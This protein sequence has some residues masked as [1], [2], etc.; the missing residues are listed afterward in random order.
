VSHVLKAAEGA[1]PGPVASDLKGMRIPI[2]TAVAVLS[3]SG[4]ALAAGGPTAGQIQPVPEEELNRPVSVEVSILDA[5]GATVTTLACDWA[6]GGPA[7]DD[8]ACLKFQ[9]D[10]QVAFG[11]IEEAGGVRADQ[12]TT[13]DASDMRI[14]Y[15]RRGDGTWLIRSHGTVDG[16][17][18]HFGLVC[19]ADG[20]S[21]VRWDADGAKYARKDVRAA[22]SKLRKRR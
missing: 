15:S 10:P 2:L 4:T 19:T 11:S 5:G 7:E 20:Q 14:A 9:S 8:S 21:C 17:E 1:T 6:T 12:H 13:T 18:L 22:A 16:K 3:L